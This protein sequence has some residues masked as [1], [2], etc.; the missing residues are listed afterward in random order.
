MNKCFGGANIAKE[1]INVIKTVGV[2][3]SAD[4]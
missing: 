3:T 1:N 4:G 2:L